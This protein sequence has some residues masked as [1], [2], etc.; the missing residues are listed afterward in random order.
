MDRQR[1]GNAENRWSQHK[2]NSPQS[3]VLKEF[4]VGTVEWQHSLSKRLDNSHKCMPESMNKG[5]TVEMLQS[6]FIPFA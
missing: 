5:G 6:L 1:A 2:M 4:L 3:A